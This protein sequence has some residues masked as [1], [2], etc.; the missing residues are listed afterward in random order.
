MGDLIN[1]CLIEGIALTPQQ[2]KENEKW[3]KTLLLNLKTIHKDGI[4]DIQD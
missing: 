4:I 2:L 3:F 1:R